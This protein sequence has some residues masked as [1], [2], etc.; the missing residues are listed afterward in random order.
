MRVG[1]ERYGIMADVEHIKDKQQQIN[2][3]F[4]IIELGGKLS[5]N[6]RIRR[7]VPLFET[8]RVFFPESIYRT[9]YENKVVEL[10][11]AFVEEEFK[12]FPVGL[13]DDMLDALS[14]ILDDDMDVTW[15]KLKEEPDR[16][17]RKYRGKK[18]RSWM[19]A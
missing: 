8:G 16:Y 13:H 18:E 6:D 3:R 15:P 14:R 17:S 5:K 1:Y 7:L 2:Y 10:V 4:D 19:T 9:N 11:Q 12:A